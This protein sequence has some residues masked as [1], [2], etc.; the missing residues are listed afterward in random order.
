MKLYNALK[1]QIDKPTRF[2]FKHNS[3]IQITRFFLGYK[4]LKFDYK[5]IR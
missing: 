1:G 3:I 4:G 2:I 5:H